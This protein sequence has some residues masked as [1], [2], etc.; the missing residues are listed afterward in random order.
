MFNRW[1]FT[2]VFDIASVLD[3]TLGLRRRIERDEVRGPRI[4]TVGEPLWTID[5]VYVRDYM[6]EN[7][8]RIPY[9]ETPDQAIVLVRY[10]P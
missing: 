8:I 4:L 7:N 9:I 5:P 6:R 2:T 3:N 10:M 1:G